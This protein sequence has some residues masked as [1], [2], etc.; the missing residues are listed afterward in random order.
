[1]F[2]DLPNF[3]FRFGSP[4]DSAVC[5]TNVKTNLKTNR[6]NGLKG[7]T[8]VELLITIAVISFGCLAAI[9]LQ[10]ASLRGTAT[11]DHMTVA[12][13]LAESEMERLKSL[14]WVELTEESDEGAK[15]ESNLDRNGLSCP[16]STQCEGFVYNR[17]VRFFKGEPTTMSTQVE[18]EVS[19]RDSTGPHNVFYTAAMT[20]LTF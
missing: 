19:W 5:Q 17:T 20:S 6:A 8:L 12:T 14:T 7:F 10:L 4:I 16:S 18:V 13:F 1:M 15:V 11:A 9:Q 2:F 3:P